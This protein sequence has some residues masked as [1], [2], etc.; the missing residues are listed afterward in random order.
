MAIQWFYSACWAALAASL[1]Y[2]VYEQIVMYRKAKGI[3]G[4]SFV[5]PIIGNLFSIILAPVEFYAR[6]QRQGPLTWNS[7]GGMF[8]LFSGDTDLVRKIFTSADQLRLFLVFGAKRI[9]GENNIAFLHGPEHQ[10]LRKQLLP[11]F[12]R[13]ALSFYIGIQEEAI[14]RHMEAW[15]LEGGRDTV[16][17]KV[18]DLN[19]ETSLKVFLGNYIDDKTREIFSVKYHEM[20]E[21]MLA[22]PI[23]YYGGTLWRAIQARKFVVPILKT[24]A[25]ESKKRMQNGLQ[26]ECLLDFWLQ[27]QV[28]LVAESQAS[29]GTI[30]MPTHT[31]D[32][33]IAEVMLDFLFASQ[34][35]STASL[36]WVLC[37][38]ADNPEVL[39][40]V[41]AEQKKARPNDEPITYEM[42]MN[43]FTYTRQVVKENLRW[44]PP[45]P[46][47]PH[48]AIEDCQ[49]TPEY[50]VPKGSIIFASMYYASS[51]GFTDG[52]K[53][54]PDRF[55]PERQEDV[56]HAKNWLIF[57]HGPHLCI[58]RE[59]AINHLVIFASLVASNL[60][61]ER[62]RT[63]DSDE[64][65]FAPC[66]QPKD[67]C[68]M[69]MKYLAGSPAEQAFNAKWAGKLATDK[70]NKEG[71][72]VQRKPERIG[73]SLM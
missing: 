10:S 41:R 31:D 20:N 3:P 32:Q 11:M 45:A 42:T 17:T 48:E 5:P 50:K 54:D 6:Q 2:M 53:F 30:P 21:G 73:A 14:R 66:V 62:F 44:R 64:I 15:V 22:F 8:L 33:H 25:A 56:K 1:G 23:A 40:K 38:L 34:D 63:P 27:H 7:V 29:N 70:S 52:H 49:L 18:R 47:M 46:M 72:A 55:S 69:E 36:M 67:G 57:G 71:G 28:Q 19:V 13:K 4:A 59:Y 16:R 61:I 26:P 51:E 37:V 12:S 39:A 24:C 65:L 68:I 35:A 43:E 58:G 60:D 9:L